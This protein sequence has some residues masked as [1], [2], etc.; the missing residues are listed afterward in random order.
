[1]RRVVLLLL[2]IL[3]ISTSAYASGADG[4]YICH[5][6]LYPIGAGNERCEQVQPDS[7]GQGIECIETQVLNSTVCD[8]YGGACY[9]IE[10]TGG[11]S[12]DGNNGS[13][14]GGP[15]DSYYCSAQ[16]QSCF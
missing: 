10:V 7:W 6:S 2:S 3:A 4:C 1:M 9:H 15:Y 12:T 8:T 14:G 16:Y 13:G 11:G 5:Y